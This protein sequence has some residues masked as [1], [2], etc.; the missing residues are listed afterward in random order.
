M[1]QVGAKNALCVGMPKCSLATDAWKIY[2]QINTI[3]SC[4]CAKV[5]I[6]TTPH[7]GLWPINV[8]WVIRLS[9]LPLL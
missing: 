6:T 2:C 9:F 8:D 3:L 5:E 7:P 1:Y 4:L